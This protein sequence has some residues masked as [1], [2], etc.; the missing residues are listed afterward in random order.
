MY[1]NTNRIERYIFYFNFR[2][3]LDFT[4]NELGIG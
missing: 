1:E 4:L 3:I 2:T